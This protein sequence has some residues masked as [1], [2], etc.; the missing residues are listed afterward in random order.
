M[1][2]DIST[3]GKGIATWV[4]LDKAEERD[5]PDAP[6]EGWRGLAGAVLG[7]CVPAHFRMFSIPHLPA[8][9]GDGVCGRGA[10]IPA[11]GATGPSR[12]AVR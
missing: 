8:L 4:K 7:L 3:R 9:L 5:R 1:G 10:R 2:I 12:E 6:P 11:G